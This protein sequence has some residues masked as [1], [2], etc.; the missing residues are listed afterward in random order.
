MR[1]GEFN[2]VAVDHDLLCFYVCRSLTSWFVLPSLGPFA[3]M[4]TYQHCCNSYFD[5]CTCHTCRIVNECK[6]YEAEGAVGASAPTS[7]KMERVQAE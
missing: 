4:Y 5:L 6:V 2:S 3:I 7:S 1:L